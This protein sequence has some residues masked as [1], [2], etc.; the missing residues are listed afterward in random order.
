MISKAGMFIC[1][2]VY[3]GM[4]QKSFY[5]ESFLFFPSFGQK[6]KRQKSI[7]NSGSKGKQR[8][9]T[10]IIQKDAK[11]IRSEN[12]VKR[13]EKERISRLQESRNEELKKK[14]WR[15]KWKWQPTPVFLPRKFHGQRSLPC[16]SSQGHKESDTTEQ[17]SIYSIMRPKERESS[18]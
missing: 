8:D 18:N 2:H 13:K 14:C 9:K 11:Q 5:L 1:T 7:K 16:Y 10:N 12:I 3:I 17:Q 6:Q 15:R 4:L